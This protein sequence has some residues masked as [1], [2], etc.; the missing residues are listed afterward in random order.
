MPAR[1][2]PA[3]GIS[4]AL[5]ERCWPGSLRGRASLTLLFIL[6]LALPQTGSTQ[7]TGNVILD[8]NEQLFCV[9]A[10]L[11]ASGYDTGMGVDTGTDTREVVRTFLAKKKIPV[12]AEIQRFYEGHMIANDP[13][14]DL[15]QYVSLAL[16][17]GPPPDFKFT[18]PQSDLPPD[19]KD[20]AGLVPLLK[21]FYQQAN[22]PDLWSRLQ[23]RYHNEILHYSEPV[24]TSIQVADAYLRFPSGA[25]LGR[26]YAIFLSVLGAPNQV[27][28]RIYGSNYFLVVTPS[29]KSR[30]NEIRY[31]YLH[32]LLDPLAVKYAQD[33]HQKA[34]LRNAVRQAPMLAK[35]FKED[36]PL[37]V[38]ECLIRAVELRM[39]KQPKVEADKALQDLAA[40][41]LILVPYFYS[42]LQD[43]EKQDT[44]MNV[45]YDSMILGIKVVAETKYA[46]SIK[47]TPRPV[48]TEN[49]ALAAKPQTEEERLLDQG[50]NSIY[51]DH[52]DEAKTA[53]QTILEKINPRSGGAFYGLAAVYSYTRKPDLAEEYF[54][55]A[56]DA[57]HDVRISTW[58]HIYLGR[59]Y[60]LK[61]KRDQAL[62]QYRAASLTATG[63]PE[64][65]QAV[66][67][68]I[69]EV[70]GSKKTKE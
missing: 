1:F 70:Y 43:Y 65:L 42:A 34:E 63:F 54:L 64:A 68:G 28:A 25:Y 58:S 16:L 15:G 66:Q 67:A 38:T 24:R 18:V 29:K 32:F 20:V 53:F 39:D 13:G 49:K 44:S 5:A 21:T 11:N 17:L 3:N 69:Q 30:L 57:T 9:L 45:Y 40:S 10:G 7:Q 50:D 22:L 52:Y 12:V 27:Q 31:Q 37:L 19:A 2:F 61:G 62:A 4:R 46:A 36:F 8:S 35:D 60:D 41:G 23:S 56:L 55:K 14:A 47:F 48:A 51:L 59:I 6:I 33:I 26:T